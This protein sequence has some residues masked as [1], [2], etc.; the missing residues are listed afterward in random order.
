MMAKGCMPSH[1][2]R[3]R[4]SGDREFYKP[5]RR[6]LFVHFRSLETHSTQ[7]NDDFF[8][9][10]ADDHFG[11]AAAGGEQRWDDGD[12][13]DEGDHE[14]DD[15]EEDNN[16]DDGRDE[17]VRVLVDL[18]LPSPHR[19]PSRLLDD[20]NPK[21]YDHAVLQCRVQTDCLYVFI[22]AQFACIMCSSSLPLA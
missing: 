22:L 1:R 9:D 7:D 16:Q 13:E 6:L 20:P 12:G 15:D 14:G 18:P 11:G 17:E 5:K 10:G 8:G 21:S 19:H 2:F 4:H 3:S